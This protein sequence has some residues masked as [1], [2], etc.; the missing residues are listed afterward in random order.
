MRLSEIPEEIFRL[1]E[2]CE[3]TLASRF[4]EIDKTA[5]INTM[6]VMDAFHDYRVSDPCFA[7][8]TGYGYDDLGRETLD[9]IFAHIFGASSAIVRIGF[10][11][12]THAIA[13]ALFAA[14]RPGDTLLSI[15]GAP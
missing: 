14:V 1:T 3:R 12:G 2:D 7:G 13:S 8:T 6:R 10:V 9:R 5:Q 4:A 11:N 15:M